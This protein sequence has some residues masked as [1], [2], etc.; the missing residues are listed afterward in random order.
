MRSFQMLIVLMAISPMAYG[1]DVLHVLNPT[2]IS[3][4]TKKIFAD[5]TD[6]VQLD[7][8]GRRALKSISQAAASGLVRTIEIDISKTPYMSW[9]WKV[10]TILNGLDET[11]KSGDDYSA[12]IYVIVSEGFFFWQTRA[13]SYVWASGQEKGSNWP[14]AFTDSATMFA[15]ESGTEHAGKWI[16]EKRNIRHDIKAYLGIDADRINAIAIMTDTDN[17][18]Q[19]ASA[20]YGDIYFMSE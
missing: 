20:Y 14:N 16:E 19:S 1:V 18:R 8:D 5:E 10:D 3:D 11:Q 4:W 15:V 6:Y 12:R 7:V 9:S 2:D 13:L 17:S